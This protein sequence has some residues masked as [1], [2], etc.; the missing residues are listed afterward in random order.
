MKWM[1]SHPSELK[2][3]KPQR[4][5]KVFELE[6]PHSREAMHDYIAQKERKEFA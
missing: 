5:F 4:Q 1:K 6:R 2:T 3:V